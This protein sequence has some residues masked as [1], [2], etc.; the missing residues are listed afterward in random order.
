MKLT[1]NMGDR[2]MRKSGGHSRW[3]AKLQLRDICAAM[4]A[5]LAAVACMKRG[6]FF[7]EDGYPIWTIWFLL[8]GAAA[9]SLLQGGGERRLGGLRHTGEMQTLGRRMAVSLAK[10]G[11]SGQAWK[12]IWAQAMMLSGPV[13]M[14]ILYAAGWIRGPLSSQGTMNELLRWSGF[15]SF[16]ILVW[17]AA[18]GYSAGRLLWAAWH[19][20]G[21]LLC[22][23][24]LL[25]FCGALPIPYAVLHSASPEV[26]AAGARLGGLLQYPNAF[27]AAMAVFLLERLFAAAQSCADHSGKRLERKGEGGG[28]AFFYRRDA[29]LSRKGEDGGGIL[30]GWTGS[31]GNASGWKGKGEEPVAKQTEP[32]AFGRRRTAKGP[33]RRE[34]LRLAPLFPYAAALL[35]SESRGAWLA[36]A[37]AAAAALPLQRRLA[38]PLLAA[39]AAPLA[40]AALLY[41]G[42]AALPAPPLPGLPLLAGLWAGAL[43]AGLWLGRR[44]Q[45]AAGRGRAA[46]MTLAA[47]AW[48]AGGAAVL[49]LVRARGTG[50]SSTV[51]ARGLMYRDALRFAAEAPWLGRGGETWRSAYLAVQSR[52][53]VGSQVHSGYLDLLL[54]VGVIG[55]AAAAISLSAAGWLIS[56]H[57]RRLLPPFLVIILHGAVDFD[58]SY[59][60]FWLLLF[61]LPALARA[62]AAG[63]GSLSGRHPSAWRLPAKILPAERSPLKYL[64]PEHM[65]TDHLSR[66]SPPKRMRLIPASAGHSSAGGR[67]RNHNLNLLARRLTAAGV[68]CLL[69]ALCLLSF[70]AYR[71]EALY[72][73]AASA[74][75][76]QETLELLD[77]SLAWNPLSPKSALALSTFVEPE[78]RVEIITAGLRYSPI[79]PALTWAMAEA[80]SETGPPGEALYWL[81]R[82]Q[83]LD[84]FNYVK[85]TEAVR[86]MLT[87]GER[88]LAE[89]DGREALRCAKMG[90]ELLRQYFLLAAET[91]GTARHNDRDFRFT[92][93]ARALHERMEAL[94]REASGLKGQSREA[95]SYAFKR[96]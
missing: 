20:V 42:L 11:K 19:A 95:E 74:R 36:A 45:H 53:Y 73:A 63:A 66:F 55:A 22:L 65:P 8:C 78:L 16:A 23:S 9:A 48:T 41:R 52:P 34:L 24:G 75:Q 39:G 92:A 33:L 14:I 89:G 90:R 2:A 76:T 18:S 28:V 96:R 56:A 77:R 38:L 87:M 68:C 86:R 46:A 59:G 44:A 49:T 69:F 3:A 29:G 7:P 80:V 15:A 72:R 13:V 62:E 1:N 54:N 88:Y 30:S 64:T 85:R 26:S 79:D 6:L 37:C 82:G 71:G 94:K 40:A 81:R 67:R 51:A 43:A 50:P 31:G 10:E 21:M 27:G 91:A 47:L 5:G 35:L 25:A 12:E 93:A 61:W 60:L 70:R 58:W 17:T 32:F 57:S 83:R 84:V 4:A